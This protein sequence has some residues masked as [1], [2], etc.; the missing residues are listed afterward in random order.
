MSTPPAADCPLCR[1][2]G[3]L[4]L[5]RGQGWRVVRAVGAEVA[6][7][8]A[9]YRV[10]AMDH[11]AE[12]SDLDA[13]QQAEGM[14]LVTAVERVLRARLQPAKLNLASLGNVVP[15]LHWHVIARFDWD[16][17]FPSPVW[18][19]ERRPADP[20]RLAAVRAALPGCDA[21]LIAALAQSA[22]P[23]A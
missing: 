16:S 9:W 3:G 2:D 21:A 1:E 5:W 7:A 23:R 6:S 18:D 22:P 4:L 10:I 8:P 19:A 15:H 11:V 13:S 20:Q 12:W 14:R 17:R